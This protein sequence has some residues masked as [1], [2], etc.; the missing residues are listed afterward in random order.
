MNENYIYEA[1]ILDT[2]TGETVVKISSYTLEGL[3]SELYKLE[4]F[5][6]EAEESAE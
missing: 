2:V 1:R 4:N 5:E 6:I 3:E